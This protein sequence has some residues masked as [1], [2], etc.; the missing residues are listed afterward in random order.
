[1]ISRELILELQQI[2]KEEFELDLPYQ[3]V[4]QIGNFLLS[5]FEALLSIEANTNK[6]KYGY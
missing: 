5:Y 3:K 2:L 4:V 1:M 6:N